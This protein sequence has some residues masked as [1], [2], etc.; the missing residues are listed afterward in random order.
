M[1]ISKG[2]TLKELTKCKKKSFL[3]LIMF[4]C[5]LGKKKLLCIGSLYMYVKL[6]DYGKIYKN[7]KRQVSNTIGL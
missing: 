1:L 6:Y 3:H 2:M 4:M 5:F 7:N